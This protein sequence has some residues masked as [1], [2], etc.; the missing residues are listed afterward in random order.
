[1]PFTLRLFAAREQNP[2]KAAPQALWGKE[3]RQNKR[4]S[5][6]A[7]ARDAKL[8]PTPSRC[9]AARALSRF[10]SAS[11]K[12]HLRCAAA[13]LL[14]SLRSKLL[15]CPLLRAHNGSAPSSRFITEIS[16]AVRSTC[17][18]SMSLWYWRLWSRPSSRSRSPTSSPAQWAASEP[19]AMQGR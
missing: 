12:T 17:S 8:A 14:A 9:E 11:A 6:K 19:Q 10:H 5:P 1:M 3:G 7:E 18:P 2:R 16:K 15:R 13:G 4:A